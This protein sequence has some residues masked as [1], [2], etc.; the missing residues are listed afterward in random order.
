MCHTRSSATPD[1]EQSLSA[2]RTDNG[3]DATEIT[4]DADS[5]HHIEGTSLSAARSPDQMGA[6]IR[7]TFRA[8]AERVEREFDGTDL[9]LSRWLTLKLIASG[10]IHCMTDV[11]REIGLV[12]GA[13]TRHVDQLQKMSLLARKRS[14]TDR[15]V[16]H[17]VLTPKGKSVVD[18]EQPRLAGFWELQLSTFSAAEREQ[19]FDLLS[20]LR[21]A[22]L[23]GGK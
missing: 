8:M 18:A 1:P 20:R 13:S 15:R 4:P 6:L 14:A 5:Q 9:T 19:L 16:I 2:S 12:S 17:I 21:G 23:D 22:L 10:R 11:N 7:D 3:T